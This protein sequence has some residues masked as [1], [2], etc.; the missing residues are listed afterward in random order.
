VGVFAGCIGGDPRKFRIGADDWD[1][2]RLGLHRQRHLVEAARK[3]QAGI[4]ASRRDGK[5]AVVTK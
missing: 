2:L 5:V 4:G 1:G 3:F